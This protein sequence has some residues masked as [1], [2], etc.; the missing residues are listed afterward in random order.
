MAFFAAAFATIFSVIDPVGVAPLFLALT[1]QIEGRERY[2][3]MRRAVT[4]AAVILLLFAFGGRALLA[5]LGI[6]VPAFSIAGGILLLLIAVDMLFART[7]RT[8][9]TPEEEEQA[10]LSTDISVFPLAIP[11][12]SGPGSIA[13]VILY[14]SQAGTNVLK[15]ISVLAAVA[16]GLGAAYVSMRLSN[17]VLRA[18]GETGINVVGRV[19]GI[20]LAALAVQFVL[21]GI[22]AYYHQSL[23]G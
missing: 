6:T 5:S 10:R 19:M 14:M 21:N 2:R 15:V 11:I 1:P 17:L 7:S 22:A 20:L 23:A 9:E 4:V 18:L 13:T 12:L 3:V 8:R 16:I